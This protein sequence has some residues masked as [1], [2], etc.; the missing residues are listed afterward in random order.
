MKKNT[1]DECFTP[2]KVYEAV[3]EWLRERTGLAGPFARPFFPGGDYENF[4][5]T[6]YIAVVDNPPFSIITKITGFY[7][8]RGIPFFLFAPGLSALR[9]AQHEGCCAIY[10]EGRLIYENGLDV[11]TAF[12]SN[13]FPGVKAMTAPDLDSAI[14]RAL[15][16]KKSSLASTRATI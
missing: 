12:V 11:R 2:P 9:A 6:K 5:Y 8:G 15:G 10:T 7:A 1:N 3:A 14:N 16:K 13:L 4:D